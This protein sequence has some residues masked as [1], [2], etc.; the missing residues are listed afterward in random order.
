MFVIRTRIGVVCDHRSES[1]RLS[2]RGRFD[3]WTGGCHADSR[4]TERRRK[5][6]R[7]ALY[8]R[9]RSWRS[10]RPGRPG[11]VLDGGLEDGSCEARRAPAPRPRSGRTGRSVS[12]PRATPF[13]VPSRAGGSASARGSGLTPR[14]RRVGRSWGHLGTR[15][16]APD[17]AAA[18]LSASG[19]AVRSA[20]VR[21]TAEAGR[22]P[23]ARGRPVVV[24][25]G[26]VREPDWA[27]LGT[28]MGRADMRMSAI[29]TRFSL[30]SR[31]PAE[32][33]DRLST[34]RWAPITG[35]VKRGDTRWSSEY[36]GQSPGLATSIIE[37]GRLGI[38]RAAA[39]IPYRLVASIFAGRPFIR[40][41]SPRYSWTTGQGRG[42][43]TVCSGERHTGQ[44]SAPR[45]W[46]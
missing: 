40:R 21:R 13:P 32:R 8:Q 45:S 23:E 35:K 26:P 27:S 11:G 3:P 41:R 28:P 10:G 14:P 37:D 34:R 31:R 4:S 6:E 42:L 30:S 12:A 7:R 17:F 33:G 39:L 44:A 15:F 36:S 29:A 19:M 20:E 24:R 18:F 22:S 38:R 1:P 5:G 2:R 16:A 25:D 9:P 43:S 46:R